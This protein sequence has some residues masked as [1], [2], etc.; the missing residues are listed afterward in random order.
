MGVGPSVPSLLPQWDMHAAMGAEAYQA[1]YQSLPN[2]AHFSGSLPAG[3]L[4]SQPSASSPPDYQ[5][6]NAHLQEVGIKV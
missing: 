5:R 1:A 2:A 4:H 3:M 6:F